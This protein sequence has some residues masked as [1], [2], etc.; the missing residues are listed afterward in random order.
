MR[1]WKGFKKGINLGGWF[2]QNDHREETYDT[3]ITEDDF[4][5]F[6][7]WG[8]DH[9]R[10]PIDYHL[11]QDEKGQ[12]L[13]S[14]FKRLDNAI[15]LCE[16][17]GLNAII[18]LHRVFG[19]SFD[20]SYGE[21]GFFDDPS[22]QERFYK[23][24]EAIAKRFGNKHGHV[25]FELL[26]EITEQS[27]S[28]RWNSIARLCIAR[29]RKIAPESD[30][31][32]GSYW[33]NSVF[34]LS[35]L[36]IKL[37]EH[38]IYS[39]HC[40]DPLIFTHQ[41][42]NWIDE[43]PLDYRYSIIGKTYEQINEEF[44]H[45]F[46]DWYANRI[47][48]PGGSDDPVFGKDYFTSSFSTAISLAE[49]RNVPLY[50]GEYGCIMYMDPKEE[51]YWFKAIHEAFEEFNLSRSAWTYKELHFGISDKRLDGVRDELLKYL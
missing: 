44:G 11:V 5:V 1:E 18:D 51:L 14:G 45:D 24:W 9:V 13:E 29:I 47:L 16:K 4:K 3:F 40:Y 32:V 28:D 43:M 20:K 33:N 17:Y 25:A 7:K 23:L 6:S 26:N 30:I 41:G 39:F 49:E 12:H 34:A 15:A 10:I 42:A 27:Y 2:S 19:F 48:V 46:P 50:C 22:L 37:D 8:I 31:L 35:D 38:I 21:S 36:D